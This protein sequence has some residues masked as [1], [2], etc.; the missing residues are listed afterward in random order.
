[1][2]A[3]EARQRRL[4]LIMQVAR[5]R[6]L[7]IDLRKGASLNAEV[8]VALF[9]VAVKLEERGIVGGAFDPR[10]DAELV[11]ELDGSGTHVVADPCSVDPRRE[12]VAGLPA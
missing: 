1:M 6:R 8:P 5:S 12:V 9:H 4:E 11:L 3:R 10:N 2:A 7:Q